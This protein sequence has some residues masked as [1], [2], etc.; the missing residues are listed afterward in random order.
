MEFIDIYCE[1]VS[2]G[3]FDEPLNALTNLTFLIAAFITW[4]LLKDYPAAITRI[5][6]VI[7][8]CIGLGSALLHT[9]ASWWGALTD[10][11][12]IAVFV[13]TYIY[14]ANRYFFHLS[15]LYSGGLTLIAFVTLIP[16]G[17]AIGTI[18]SF[19]GASTSYAS[20]A[21]LIFLYGIIMQ[22]F[23]RAVGNKLLIGALILSISI[24]FR[25]VDDP[26][27]EVI[28]VG[29]HWVWHILNSIM[30]S[31]MIIILRDKIDKD[32]QAKNEVEI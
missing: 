16:V 30:L 24:G 27:C 8:F 3:L 22:K 11:G 2:A 15:S 4:R 14:A 32:R 29:T 6:C 21:A 20:I 5:L 9:T 28:P 31:Y 26:L 18:F 10:I 13:I 17:W 1:R 23:D 12:F 25:I 7:L 19:I